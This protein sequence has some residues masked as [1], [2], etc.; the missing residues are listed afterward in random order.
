MSVAYKNS[1]F[2]FGGS[3]GNARNDFYEYKFDENIWK[4]VIS[5]GGTPPCS[6]FCH[7]GVVYNKCFYV[8]GGYDGSQRL[9]DFKQFRLEEDIAAIPESTLTSDL[10]SYINNDTFSDITFIVEGKPIHAHKLLVCRCTYFE[11]MF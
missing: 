2:I 3:T 10:M 5:E 7:A 9:N 1:L 6:R 11:A 4:P 8:F